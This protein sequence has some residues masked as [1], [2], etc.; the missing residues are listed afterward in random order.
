MIILQLPK[1]TSFIN[2]AGVHLKEVFFIPKLPTLLSMEI[3]FT[4]TGK[5]QMK[6]S[7]RDCFSR[8][9]IDS[10]ALSFH[11]FSIAIH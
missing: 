2:V 7:A 4:K 11:I 3:L 6:N 8:E 1:R 9:I 5:L 10:K